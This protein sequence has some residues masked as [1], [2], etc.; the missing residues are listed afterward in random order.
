M[1]R[2]ILDEFKTPVH[3]W[4]DAINTACHVINRVYI[5]MFL[6]KTSYE[7]LTGNNP[8]VGYFRVFGPPCFIHD[9]HHN[10]KFAAKAH[11]GFF[12]RIYRCAV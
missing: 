5:H 7:P 9:K 10:S 3:F 12:I 11:E 8:N 2:I 1:T 6:T 4:V